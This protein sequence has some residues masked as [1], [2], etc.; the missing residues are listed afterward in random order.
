LRDGYST[1]ATCGTGL[2]A[3]ARLTD[4][5]DIYSQEGLG[6]CLVARLF[7]SPSKGTAPRR[8]PPL[9]LGTVRVPAP[10]ETDCGDNWGVRAE[11]G[12]TTV[13]LADGL[14]HGPRAAEASGEAV[15]ALHRAS[16]LAPAAVLEQVHHALR[17][18]RGAAV[19]IAQVDIEKEQVRFA[20]AGR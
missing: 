18:T 6:T 14:G 3:I 10:G 4:E 7:S 15:A 9:A 8:A 5:F 16:D 12:R 13:L 11:E 19:A 2:G 17:S 1:A 20:G